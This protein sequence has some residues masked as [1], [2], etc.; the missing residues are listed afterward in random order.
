MNN[1]K[2]SDLKLR[3]ITATVIILVISF[4][5]YLGIRL[6]SPLPLLTLGIAILL[7]ASRELSQATFTPHSIL[8][9]AISDGPSEADRS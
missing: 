1:Q 8:T 3:V 6:E 4:V 9:E 2:Q 7:A 5:L